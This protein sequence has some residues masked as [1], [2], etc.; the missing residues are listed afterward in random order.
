M[1]ERLTTQSGE[2]TPYAGKPNAKLALTPPMGDAKVFAFFLGLD[3]PGLPGAPASVTGARGRR[4]ERFGGARASEQVG[5]DP[6][7]ETSAIITTWGSAQIEVL[8]HDGGTTPPGRSKEVQV[9]SGTRGRLVDPLFDVL[10]L[11]RGPGEGLGG[12]EAL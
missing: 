7:R 1:L 9:L 12:P 11:R 10:S 2:L 8:I 5:K 3:D 4:I 6:I